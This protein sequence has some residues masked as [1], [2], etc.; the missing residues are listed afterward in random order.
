MVKGKEAG[1]QPEMCALLTPLQNEKSNNLMALQK[2]PGSSAHLFYLCEL[3][4][5]GIVLIVLT[6]AS[7]VVLRLF[8][9]HHVTQ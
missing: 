2:V 7:G 1:R 3:N 8:E 4:D 6:T 5:E 9:N